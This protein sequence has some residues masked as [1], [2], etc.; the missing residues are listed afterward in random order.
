MFVRTRLFIYLFIYLLINRQQKKEKRLLTVTFFWLVVTCYKTISQTF[1]LKFS[2]ELLW[3]F[4]VV[5]D[6]T[7]KHSLECHIRYSNTSIDG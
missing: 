6:G 2:R 1:D 5:R 4:C 3:Y 7:V